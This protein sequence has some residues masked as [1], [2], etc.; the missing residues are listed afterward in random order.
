MNCLFNTVMKALK[1]VKSK[2]I[3]TKNLFLKD[4]LDIFHKIGNRNKRIL[5]RFEYLKFDQ[6]L[7]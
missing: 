6:I 4:I 2:S 5:Y 1:I 3:K 7:N